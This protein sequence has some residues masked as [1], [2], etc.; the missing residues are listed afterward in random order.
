MKRLFI[1]IYIALCQMLLNYGL[2]ARTV[3][4]VVTCGGKE[5]DLILRGG[6]FL[7]LLKGRKVHIISGHNHINMNFQYAPDVIEHNVAAICGTWWDAYHCKDGTPR[8]Y[9]VYTKKDKCLT[10]FEDGV[11]KGE[12]TRVKEKNHLHKAE[13]EATFAKKGKPV[14]KWKRTSVSNHYFAATPSDGAR[15]ITV[16]I[17]NPFG[18]KWVENINLN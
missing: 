4:G 17:Q 5:T 8:G 7:N 9:K 11:C 15:M 2:H 12:M 6:E 13:L 10:W 3:E 1:L 18:K 14:T 16:H